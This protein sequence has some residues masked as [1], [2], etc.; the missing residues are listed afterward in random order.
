MQIILIGVL[1]FT[2]VAVMEAL[3]YTLRFVT[4]RREG[5]AQAA[6]ASLGTSDAKAIHGLLRKGKLS[7]SPSSTRSCVRI[8]RHRSASRT[9]SSRPSSSITVARLLTFCGAGAF[10]RFILG[11]LSDGG[12][13]MSLILVVLF[14]ALPHHVRDCSCARGAAASS[15]SSSPT[16]SR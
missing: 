6:P 3:V 2:V 4:D 14:G 8:S 7:A 10:L 16:R 12:P 15:P 5:R 1:A 11:L 9:C 13:V